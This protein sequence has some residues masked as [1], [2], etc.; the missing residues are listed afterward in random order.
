MIIVYQWLC[1]VRDNVNV[2]FFLNVPSP[3]WLFLKHFSFWAVQHSSWK[4]Q[5]GKNEIWC[6]AKTPQVGLLIQWKNIHMKHGKALNP[7]HGSES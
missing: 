2:F 1:S 6:I 4:V 5:V 7:T 3:N